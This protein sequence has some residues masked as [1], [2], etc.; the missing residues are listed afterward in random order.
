M[1]GEKY[2]TAKF[3][4]SALVGGVAVGAP[5]CITM[6][7]MACILIGII[8]SLSAIFGYRILSPKLKSFFGLYDECDQ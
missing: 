2:T 4:Q 6:S 1:T 5:C 7:P 3:L 8:A